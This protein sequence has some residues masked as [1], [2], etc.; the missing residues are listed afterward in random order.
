MRRYSSETAEAGASP[1]QIGRFA[2]V[3]IAISPGEQGTFG[4]TQHATATR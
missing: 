3:R 1:Y 2:L 4:L